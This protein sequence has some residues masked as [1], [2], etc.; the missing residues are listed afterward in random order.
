MVMID[1]NDLKSINDG[2][3]HDAG[4]IYIVG[5]TKMAAEVYKNSQIFRVG[6]DEIVVILKD[7]DYTNRYRLLEE[8]QR[9][10][11]RTSK[12]TNVKPYE[13]FS[14]A[15]GM[16]TYEKGV[17]KNVDAVFQKADKAM[18][19]NKAEIKNS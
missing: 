1:I 7:E 2:Y 6:G 18:Y 19:E 16:A 14:A 9:Q 8:L 4:N 13:R 10:Y 15:A 11:R 17:D 3:G 5:A 12:N